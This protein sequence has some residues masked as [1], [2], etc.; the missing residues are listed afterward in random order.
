MLVPAYMDPTMISAASIKKVTDD[1]TW[2]TCS[3]TNAACPAY[4]SLTDSCTLCVNPT[5][6]TME[7]VQSGLPGGSDWGVHIT[8]TPPGSMN[9]DAN[10]SAA[11]A[12]NYLYYLDK[13]ARLE[14]VGIPQIHY[15][16]FT[17]TDNHKNLV[18]G[19]FNDSLK[20]ITQFQNDSQTFSATSVVATGDPT[21]PQ[22]VATSSLGLQHDKVFSPNEFKCCSQLGQKVASKNLC[23]SGHGVE[24]ADKKWT[25]KLPM[26]TD[27]NVYYNRFVTS[28]ATEATSPG[29]GF[30]DE[31]FNE[32]TGEPKMTDDVY[33]KLNA[34]GQ[35]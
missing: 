3:I 4:T 5:A 6:G 12:G 11:I 13:L 28:E 8:F 23:C 30:V 35:A 10:Q 31:D 17:C 33:R 25:C 9:Y 2:K 19:I 22:R 26:G 20:T 1:S 34:L 24:G 14:L 7:I 27:L 32:N 21:N 18:P 29:G 15:E 16:P